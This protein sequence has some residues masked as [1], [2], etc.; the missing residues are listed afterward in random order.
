VFAEVFCTT[1]ELPKAVPCSRQ[2][3]TP[4]PVS[5]EGFNAMAQP[6]HHDCGAKLAQSFSGLKARCVS[7][8]SYEY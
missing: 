1:L 4:S 2:T 5:L 3:E 6:M 8:E 7:R